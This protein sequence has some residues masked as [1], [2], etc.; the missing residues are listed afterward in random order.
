MTTETPTKRYTLRD[1][2]AEVAVRLFGWRW[3]RF[4]KNAKAAHLI[5]L[6]PPMHWPKGK[7]FSVCSDPRFEISSGVAAGYSEDVTETAHEYQRDS[8]WDVFHAGRA[9]SDDVMHLPRFASSF[10]DM[11]LVIEELRTRGYLVELKTVPEGLN[12]WTGDG[13]ERLPFSYACLL[14]YQRGRE[15]T[16]PE[17]IRRYIHE[18]ISALAPSLPLALSLAA[19]QVVGLKISNADIDLPSREA[20]IDDSR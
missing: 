3:R 14:T 5:Y 4:A 16:S 6:C 1:I 17:E 15:S 10:C 12:F 19:L 8:Y 7:I 13:L 18:H 2:D 9:D 20:D 11:D